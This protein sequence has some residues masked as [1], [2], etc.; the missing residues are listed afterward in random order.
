MEELLK[1]AEALALQERF[2]EELIRMRLRKQYKIRETASC[3]FH[4]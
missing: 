1:K 2:D 3:E 4:R